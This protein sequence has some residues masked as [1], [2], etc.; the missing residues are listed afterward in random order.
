MEQGQITSTED[1][2]DTPA[3]LAQRWTIEVSAAQKELAKFH[4][5]AKRINHRYLDK[6]EDF[7]RDQ[8]RVNLFW[9]TVQV[10]L[11]MLYARPRVR[12]YRE[13]GRTRTTIRRALRAR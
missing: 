11:S 12:T 1:F 2:K 13:V 8:S 4:E 6:R 3:G 10:L 5:D 7:G 9:S